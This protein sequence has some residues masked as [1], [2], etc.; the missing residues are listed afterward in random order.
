MCCGVGRIPEG[1]TDWEGCLEDGVPRQ[2]AGCE[3]ARD[4]G[5]ELVRY[6]A[7]PSVPVHM[8]LAGWTADS[9]LFPRLLHLLPTRVLCS[10]QGTVFSI[11]QTPIKT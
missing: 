11:R 8:S 3:F 9:R 6:H 5:N 4:K 1:G 2:E 10:T 7:V